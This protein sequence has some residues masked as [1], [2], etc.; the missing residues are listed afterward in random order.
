MAERVLVAVMEGDRFAWIRLSDHAA[1]EY[2]P[3]AELAAATAGREVVALVPATVTLLTRA[4]VPSNSDAVIEKAVPY[5][6]EDRLAD[7]L[8]AVAIVHSPTGDRLTR[9][10]AVVS[11]AVIDGIVEAIEKAGVTVTSA[12][13]EITLLPNCGADWSIL[14]RDGVAIV[15]TGQRTG[16]LLNTSPLTHEEWDN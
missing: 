8:G 15:R 14:L 9:D 1:A 12:V 7:E 16:F 3:V 10:V 4:H 13:P 5:A 11:H 6:V 2:G